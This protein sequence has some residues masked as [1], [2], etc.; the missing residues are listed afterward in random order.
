MSHRRTRESGM[1]LIEVLVATSLMAVAVLAALLLYDA[2]RKSFKKGEN[3]SEQQ[4]AVRIAFDRL[5]ADLRMAG[6][7]YNPDGAT[8]RPDEQIEAAYDT[9]IVLRADF[10]AEDPLAN[11]VPE[12]DL[13]G[14]A[15]LS[16]ST[17]NDEIVAYVLAKPD[18]SS[19]GTLTFQAD[20]AESKRDGDVETVTI[21]NVA[22]VQDDPPYTL[23][24]ISL[25]ND[26]A[27]W[28]TSAFIVRTPLV[29]NVRSMTFRYYNQAGNLLNSTFDLSSTADDIGGSDA[30][31]PK[32]RRASIRRVEISLVGLTREPDLGWVDPSDTNP[33]TRSYRKFELRGDVT[34]RNLGMV[35][36]RDLSADLTPP[37]K[38]G[39]P[40]LYPGHCGGLYVTW[41]A[42]PASDQVASYRINYGT[43]PGS[44]PNSRSTPN[45]S[46]YLGGLATG[47]TYYVTIQAVD[48]AGNLSPESNESSQ[49]VT[50]TTTP[51]A[52][53]GL[54]ASKNLNGAV[55][56]SWTAVT[57]NTTN[58]T[59]DPASP[60]IRD[61][62]GYRV[63]RGSTSDF[64]PAP[65]NR[66]ADETK[67]P[68]SSSPLYTDATAVNCRSYFYK[69]TAAD[70]CGVEGE[71][72]AAASGRAESTVAPKPPANVQAFLVGLT[73]ARITWQAVTQDVQGRPITIDTYVVFRSPR[74]AEG[75]D[76]EG[77]TY[78][79]IATVTG[80][81]EY[82]DP[83]M[84][85]PV[86]GTTIWYRV[87]ARDD[88]PNESDFSN[89]AEPACAFS[90]TVTITAPANGAQVAGVVPTTVQVSGGSDT[91]VKATFQ[92]FNNT[93]GRLEKEKEISGP[94]PTWTYNWLA[95]PP[96]SY[97]ITAIVEN[98]DGCTRSAEIEVNAGSDVGCCLSPHPVQNPYVM[99]C[100]GDP[101]LSKKCKK[102]T[103]SMINN[104]C[105]T[106]VQVDTMEITW[107][108][109]IGN[110]AKLEDVRFDGA[111]IWSAGLASSPA[112]TTF[113][114]PKPTIGADRSSS[115]PVTV[116][117]KYDKLMSD[118]QGSTVKKNAPITT[119][120]TFTLLD[121]Q[122]QPSSVR[123]ACGPAEGFNFT[124]E[125][126]N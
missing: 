75:T 78:T 55:T 97:T 32:A 121:A 77:L 120:F 16:V 82:L 68:A 81:T 5:N 117:Y 106:A 124:V 113:S 69:V 88:C 40:S 93:T 45:T 125:D 72:S 50:N 39:A 56:T 31:T 65:G 35:G 89:A 51:K 28:G 60:L 74:V 98:E 111:V 67:V 58:V 101:G 122:G 26:P 96:G 126:P 80:A 9:A 44:H 49:T 12:N 34:P 92:F 30:S 4:Q 18:G 86:P 23:Y 1:S 22:L 46:Y 62:A 94:G 115:N 112:S 24:R 6:F 64:A 17:G 99:K 13:A 8:N 42:N 91:Y 10:D 14:G 53:T 33:K 57:E 7:N 107:T 114:A 25:N 43:S 108:N 83:G 3:A 66:I 76:P 79:A 29:D 84:G 20:V 21:P 19:T 116:D 54:Q 90:G 15:F 63:Y 59:G 41:P 109:N 36:I 38:P 123:G 85:V 61:L 119:T 48:A 70:S 118:K 102:I 95:D 47:T 73:K 103:Y 100:T 110:N 52:V 104:N 11:S 71:A 37:S 2:A 87:K 27:T 105:L